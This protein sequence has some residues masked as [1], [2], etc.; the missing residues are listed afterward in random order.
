M[1]EAKHLGFSRVNEKSFYTNLP[2]KCARKKATVQKLKNFG[3]VYS[4]ENPKY[5]TTEV[6]RTVD[7]L[8]ITVN[9]WKLAMVHKESFK[10][11]V[12]GMF[13]NYF[14]TTRN[15]RILAALL[16]ENCK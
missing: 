1:H 16:E 3:V 2:I 14:Y 13:A 15:A 10:N 6:W 5:F 4:L 8:F 9:T 12:L 11:I 7:D